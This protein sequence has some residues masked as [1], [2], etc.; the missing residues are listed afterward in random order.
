[1]VRICRG[2]NNSAGG[3]PSASHGEESTSG[4]PIHAPE[5]PVRSVVD[6]TATVPATLS[7]PDPGSQARASVNN[8][9]SLVSRTRLASI[10]GLMANNK[11][12]R[13]FTVRG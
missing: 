5:V 9:F 4:I 3:H 13:S 8:S 12:P 11:A 1:M 10:P 6:C 2:Y 7:P